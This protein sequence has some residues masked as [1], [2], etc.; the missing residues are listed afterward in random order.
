MQK[1][2]VLDYESYNANMHLCRAGKNAKVTA[3]NSTQA[4]RLLEKNI[5]GRFQDVVMVQVTSCV[6]IG[7]IERTEKA[8]QT[9]SLKRR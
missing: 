6:E 4:I 8:S 9:A 3:D 7:T 5:K 1:T 2:F